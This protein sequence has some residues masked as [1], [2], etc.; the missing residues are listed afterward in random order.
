MEMSM[1]IL[2]RK[3]WSRLALGLAGTFLAIQLVPYGRDHT[4]PAISGE[5][6]W[7]APAT[8]ALAKQ[9][10]FDCHSNETKWPAYASI[11]PASWLVQRDVKEGRAVLNFSEWTRPQEEAN[12]AAEEVREGEMPPAA[13]TLL[14]PQARLNPADRDRLAQGLAKTLG[15]ALKQEARTRDR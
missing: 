15:V 11:A 9:A 14:H 8:R 4:N 3:W 6:A 10:C 7:D 2:N 12:E 13:Y 1:N 5:P